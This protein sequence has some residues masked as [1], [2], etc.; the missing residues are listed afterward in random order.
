MKS[1]KVYLVAIAALVMSAMPAAAQFR[2]GPRVGVDVNSM[3]LEKSVFNSDNRAGFTAGLT[4][5]FTVPL[6]GIG[7]DLSAMYVHRANDISLGNGSVSNMLDVVTSKEFKS[8]DYIEIPVNLKYKLDLPVIN[9]I[10]VP[11]AFT[12]P[13]FSF[14]ASK[15]A[16]T[17]A[18]E[19]KTFDWAWN[20]G[21]G[22]QFFSHLQVSASYGWGMNKTVKFIGNVSGAD[23]P[24]T[25]AID[26]KNK[27][28]TITAAYL[29]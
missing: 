28:W 21:L 8:R 27:Y 12:G 1:L 5:E 2:F 14:L 9:K 26:G 19:N 23:L 20:V 4:A 18:Y 25:S 3:K 13:S 17:A 22:L 16:I 6:I 24:D 7:F 29:F 15:K 10:L 11:Y